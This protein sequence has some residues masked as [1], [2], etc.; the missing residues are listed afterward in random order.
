MPVKFSVCLI[1]ER[2]IPL[3]EIKPD[4]I[5]GVFFSL[6]D[7]KLGEELHKPS[8]IKP[9]VLGIPK[10]FRSEESVERIFLRISFLEDTLFPKFLSSLLLHEGKDIFINDIKLK[11][12]KKP[13]I[14]ERWIK[15]YETLYKDSSTEKTIVFDFIT[16]TS[17]KRGKKDYPLPDPKLIF[18]G[19]IRKWLFFSD[20]RID[21]DLR[22]VIEEDIEVMG[23]WIR[24][25]K[26]A[27]S[28]GKITGFTGRVVLYINNNNKEILK[29][30]N[31]LAKFSE[32]AGVGR[33]TTMGF[34]MV[35][36]ANSTESPDIHRFS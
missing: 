4:K 20:I 11:K 15:T 17:F 13:F 12:L 31:T 30:I 26:I 18:K 14:D 8:R 33:K 23:A 24:T 29:W 28:E 27:L 21:T 3:S 5:H 35:K 10:L 19:L 7:R 36:L 25:K 34:G 1:P 2:P 6:I 22:K 32:F 16:P 9:F